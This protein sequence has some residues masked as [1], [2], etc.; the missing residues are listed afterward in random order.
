MLVAR[1]VRPLD[2]PAPAQPLN[3]TWSPP[4]GMVGLSF[5]NYFLR[6]ITLGI[7]HFWGKTEVR[8]RIWS[9]I[10]INGE[11]LHYTGTGR[12]LFLG[13][14][15][16]FALVL[17]PVFAVSVVSALVFGPNSPI[18]Y[19]VQALTYLVVF[20]LIGFGIWRAMRYRLSRT[21]WRGIRAGLEGSQGRY[22]WTYIWTAILNPFTL[23]WLTP[24]RTTKLQSLMV[25]DMRFGDRP[26]QF[27][28]SSGPLYGRFA[29]LWVGGI[30]LYAGMFGVL[31][32]MFYPKFVAA[33]ESGRPPL[34]TAMDAVTV[35]A[36]LFVFLLLLGIVGAWYRAKVINHFAAHTHFEGATFRGTAT[37]RGLIW[38]A[39]SN[40]LISILSLG[41]LAPIAQMRSARYQVQNLKIDGAVPLAA[42]AQGAAASG[43]YGEGLAQAFDFDAF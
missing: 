17:L 37:A 35:F 13:F 31:G 28:A 26:L 4:S 6:I 42:I 30:I 10:R 23:G 9:S 20:T 41:I 27:N 43:K 32:A 2:Q 15:I 24:W 18:A 1:S 38:L 33:H 21:H 39:I 34:I 25:S 36:I 3:L 7:Y 14:L 19:A 11:P 29:G 40:F 22:A 8:R 5:I 16:V 12:E